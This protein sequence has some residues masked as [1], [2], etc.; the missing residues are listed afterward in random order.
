MVSGIRRGTLR[1]EKMDNTVIILIG[2]GVCCAAL[3]IVLFIRL[4]MKKPDREKEGTESQMAED[5]AE[6]FEE[7]FADTGNIE[8]TLSQLEQIYSDNRYMHNLI[9][10]AIDY[11]QNG[12]G[13]FETALEGINA[14]GDEEIAEMHS[15]AIQKSIGMDEDEPPARPRKSRKS[16][17]S[18]SKEEPKRKRSKHIEEEFDEDYDEDDEEEKPV[19]KKETRKSQEKSQEKSQGKSTKKRSERRRSDDDSSGSD[20]FKI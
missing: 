15:R 12:Y 3:G 6:N 7:C 20:S 18:R 11:I 1:K 14:D 4:M 5:Y 13:D 17:S 8:D 16:Q 9:L 2:A 19:R 10:N